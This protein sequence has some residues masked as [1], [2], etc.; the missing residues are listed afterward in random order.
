MSL[1]RNRSAGTNRRRCARAL[2]LAAGLA[3]GAPASFG[4]T[5]PVGGYTSFRI[6]LIGPG[7]EYTQ[8]DGTKWFDVTAKELNAIG[9][10]IGQSARYSA[11]GDELGEDAWLFDGR[12]ARAIGL[13]GEGFEY[14]VAWAGGIHRRSVVSDINSYGQAVGFSNRFT[15]DGADVGS[16][17]WFYDGSTTHALPGLTGASYE[18][19]NATGILVRNSFAEELNDSGQIIGGSARVSPSGT[20]YLGSDPYYFD[21]TTTQRIGL[22]GSDYEYERAGG[23]YRLGGAEAL[24]TT[25]KVF[26]YTERR[27]AA[28]TYLGQDAWYFD[29]TTTRQIGITGSEYEYAYDGEGAGT[30]RYTRPYAINDAGHVIGWTYH[31]LPNSTLSDRSEAW[32]FDGD[33]T[34]AIGPGADGPV[35]GAEGAVKFSNNAIR[36]N[37]TGQVAG[38]AS[39]GSATGANLGSDAWFFDGSATRILGLSGDDYEH[40][41]ADGTMRFGQPSQLNNLGYVAGT[42]ERYTS[43]GGPAGRDAWFF[44]GTTTRLV[45]LTGD[46]YESST[47]TSGEM[48]RSSTPYLMNDAGQLV[49]TSSRY[50]ENT[51]IGNT[52][53]FFDPATNTTTEMVLDGITTDARIGVNPEFLTAQGV[54]LG[55]YQY[56]ED[57]TFSG[58]AF[59][60]SLEAGFHDMGDLVA[61]D[62][63]SY[64]FGYLMVHQ[65]DGITDAG[66]SPRF[67]LGLTPDSYANLTGPESAYLAAASV[68]P[69]RC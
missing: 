58:G 16:V 52:G 1:N 24:T 10:V 6:G 48:T 59:W 69:G 50:Y 15:A 53:W 11:S 18:Y 19:V 46:G 8:W 49:G 30:H 29:G 7:Y 34:R 5:P 22:V 57:G 17:P 32:L 27:N 13:L 55:N 68:P 40:V 56:Q 23:I 64:W 35:E 14:E 39:R 37:E 43:S 31:Y 9:H 28:R 51:D 67:L 4:Q 66:D 62:S 65:I 12:S 38:R 41:T 45:G 60:W 2:S 42:M 26:G 33:T 36:L 20:N 47:G 63:R 61:N 3:L 25:G 21:G 44:D 54:V